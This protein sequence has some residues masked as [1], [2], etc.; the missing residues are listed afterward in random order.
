MQMMQCL[1]CMKPF[2]KPVREL[3]RQ[4][5]IV[6]LRTVGSLPK[7]QKPSFEEVL[8]TWDQMQWRPCPTELVGGAILEP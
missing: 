4:F 8:L 3:T 7:G 6:A 1:A 2:R 5:P